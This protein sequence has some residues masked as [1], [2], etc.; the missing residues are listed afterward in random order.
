MGTRYGGIAVSN[1][2][3]TSVLILIAAGSLAASAPASS[4]DTPFSA[5]QVAADGGA[6]IARITRL[7]DPEL[8]AFYLRCTRAAMRGGMA[9][10]EVALCSV[11]YETLLRRTFSGDFLALLDWRR[12]QH[13]SR[14][15]PR[16]VPPAR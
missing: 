9:S 5:Q 13:R 12:A 15:A 1:P 6:A 14:N 8:K 16:E 11:G 3:R 4:A 10:G 2:T 7:A